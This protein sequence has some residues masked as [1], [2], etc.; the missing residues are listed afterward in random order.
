M[1]GTLERVQVSPPVTRPP[2]PRRS[3]AGP[4]GL[5]QGAE[6]AV[7]GGPGPERGQRERGTRPEGTIQPFLRHVPSQHV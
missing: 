4:V 6:D 7:A 1:G 5:G 3:P 2:F